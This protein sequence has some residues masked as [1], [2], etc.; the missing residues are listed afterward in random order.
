ME[1]NPHSLEAD[2][3]GNL[4]RSALF[5]VKGQTNL[6]LSFYKKALNVLKEKGPAQAVDTSKSY[7]TL[8]KKQ[9]LLLAEQILD[10]YKALKRN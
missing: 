2:A 10:Q 8:T 5:M 4:Y 1:I 3:L 9:R 7:E 6:S